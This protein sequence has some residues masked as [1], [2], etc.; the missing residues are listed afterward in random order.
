MPSRD[1]REWPSISSFVRRLLPRPTC[2]LLSETPP[3]E[4]D[5]REVCKFI[6]SLFEALRRFLVDAQDHAAAGPFARP[7]VTG[8]DGFAEA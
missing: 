8:L 4:L 1:G 6:G 7:V 5:E 2:S 3:A